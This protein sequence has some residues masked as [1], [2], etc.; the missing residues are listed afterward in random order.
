MAPAKRA[1]PP[2]REPVVTGPVRL[3]KLIAQGGL[4]SRRAAEELITEGRVSVNGRI[5]RELGF[6]A[7]PAVDHIIVD[8]H[9]LRPRTGPATVV[10]LHKPKGY[11]TSKSDPEGRPTVMDLLPQRYRTL[12]P[13][14]R[15]DYD[16]SGL[17][18][19]TDDGALLQLLTHPS[20]GVQKTYWARVRGTVTEAT[21]TRLQSGVK[22]EDG[23][24]A[25]CRAAVRAQTANNALVEVTLREGRNRQVRRMLEAVGHPVRA[26]RRIRFGALDVKGLPLGAHRVLLPGEVHQLR[27]GATDKPAPAAPRSRKPHK[28]TNQPAKI[29]TTRAQRSSAPAPAKNRKAAKGQAHPLAAR[30]DRQ[31]GEKSRG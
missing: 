5:V 12:N 22:L 4:A 11:V 24:T 10:L 25:P 14:G 8:G 21:I 2:R 7:D 9:S 13:V 19:L 31:W 30:I 15:L 20:H 1:N 6:K 18:L 17:L 26:L 3:Q 23:K 29:H 28:P 27:R 16:T